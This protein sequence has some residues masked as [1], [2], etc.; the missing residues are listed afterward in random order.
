MEYLFWD[1]GRCAAGTCFEVGL[2][3][4]AANVFLVDSGNFSAYQRGREYT[5]YGGFYDFTPLTLEVPHR[6]R[7]YQVVDGYDDDITVDFEE[8]D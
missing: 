2:D 5:Y 1:L 4:S 6:G 7:W 8:L 3:G